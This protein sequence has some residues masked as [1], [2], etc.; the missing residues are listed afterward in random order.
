MFDAAAST[1]IAHKTPYPVKDKS[2]FVRAPAHGSRMIL[3]LWIFIEEKKILFGSHLPMY[4]E[5]V[6][7]ADDEQSVDFRC[8]NINIYYSISCGA[9]LAH[10]ARTTHTF[11]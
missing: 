7:V 9:G 11:R 4:T 5:A 6:A 10:T 1:L 8:K 2:W 3:Y